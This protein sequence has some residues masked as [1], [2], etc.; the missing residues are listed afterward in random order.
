MKKK[1]NVVKV[2]EASEKFRVNEA[3]KWTSLSNTTV[4]TA[5]GFE[6]IFWPQLAMHLSFPLQMFCLSFAS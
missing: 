2:P 6:G 4:V 3:L 1:T 5:G